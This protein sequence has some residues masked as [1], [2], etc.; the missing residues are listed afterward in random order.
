MFFLFI[1]DCCGEN[2]G[3]LSEAEHIITSQVECNK[4]LVYL[5]G[6]YLDPRLY[7]E[8]NGTCVNYS[9]QAIARLALSGAT[10]IIN[11]VDE[12]INPVRLALDF[13][14]RRLSLIGLSYRFKANLYISTGNT[15]GVKLH[16]D[17]HDVYLIQTQGKKIWTINDGENLDE[18]AV[19]SLSVGDLLFLARGTF[20]EAVTAADISSHLTVRTLASAPPEDCLLIARHLSQAIA[21][22]DHRSYAP[23]TRGKEAKLGNTD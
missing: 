1:K 5:H 19:V 23:R 3:F 13:T 20:H 14:E 4:L 9:R 18:S 12:L 7:T 10:V 2:L 17:A 11:N 22:L 6:T 8:R 16:R 21:E 15:I